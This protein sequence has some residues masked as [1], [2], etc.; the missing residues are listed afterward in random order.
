MQPYGA[1]SLGCDLH[2]IGAAFALVDLSEVLQPSAPIAAGQALRHAQEELQKL[3]AEI[4]PSTPV[5]P[6]P[7]L[8]DTQEEIYA[9]LADI[10]A[11]S[12]ASRLA[13]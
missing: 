10:W 13:G 6:G 5:G 1:K 9:A 11:G 2:R 12:D 8:R 4:Q 7:L 3:I